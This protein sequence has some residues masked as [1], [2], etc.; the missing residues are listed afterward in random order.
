MNNY[1]KEETKVCP[2]ES[3]GFLDMKLRKLFQNPKKILKPYIKK[4]MNVLDV[5]CGPGFFT[6]KISE[7]LYWTGKVVGADL[8]EEMLLKVKNKV[9]KLKL[10]NVELHKTEKKFDKFKWKSWF[11]FNFLYAPWSS[12]SKQIYKWIKEFAE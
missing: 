3:S 9:E 11:C 6:I 7:L 2:A 1:A 4:N 12:R 5:D 10:N 8:Q